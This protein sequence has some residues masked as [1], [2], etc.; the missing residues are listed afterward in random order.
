MQ[1]GVLLCVQG[2][3]VGKAPTITAGSAAGNDSYTIS[4]DQAAAG[5]IKFNVLINDPGKTT[6]YSLDD[7]QSADLL[8]QDAVLAPQQSRLGATI[9]ITADGQLS[10]A[11]NS[12]TVQALAVGETLQDSFIYAVRQQNGNLIWQTVTVTITGTNDAPV[13]VADV[14]AVAEDALATGSVAANDRDVDHNA[15][16]T[17]STTDRTPA[18]FT[19]ASNG[20]WAFDGSNAAYQSLA[21]GQTQQF[22]IQY[23]A[24]DQY[25]A[26]S[27]STLTLTVTGRNDAPAAAT[28][29]AAAT[30]DQTVTGQLTAT[31]VD[32]GGSL[33]FELNETAPAG[34]ALNANGSWSFD[35]SSYDSLAAGQTQTIT[36]RYAAVDGAGARG[37]AMLFIALTGTNAAPI[38]SAATASVGESGQASGAVSVTDVDSTY[39]VEPFYGAPGG[40]SMGADGSWSF[41]ASQGDYQS[42][43]AGESQDVVIDYIVTDDAGATAV[44]TLTITVTGENDAPTAMPATAAVAEDGTVSGQVQVS[45]PDANDSLTVEPPM[46]ANIAGFEMYSDG[47][48]IFDANQAE[49]Q[50]LAQGETRDI[51]INYSVS[52]IAGAYDYST[53]T[54]TITGANDAPVTTSQWIEAVEGQQ[55]SGTLIAF[56]QDNGAQLSF[57]ITGDAP[58]GLVVNADG[59]WVF[60]GSNSAYDF[61]RAGETRLVRADFSVTDEFGASASSFVTIAVTGTNDGPVSNGSTAVLAGSAEDTPFTFN[62]DDLLAGWS[63]PEGDPLIVTNLAANHGALTVE[64]GIVTYLPEANYNGPVALSYQVADA[65]GASGGAGSAT[66]A[67]SPVNDAPALTGSQAAPSG[68][69]DVTLTVTQAQLLQGWTDVEGSPLSISNVTANSGARITAN[70]NGSYSITPAANWNGTLQLSYSVSDGAATTAATLPVSFAATNDLPRLTGAAYVIPGQVEDTAFT[71]TTAQLLQGWTDVDGDALSIWTISTPGGSVT[72]N[73]D[74]TY[75]V[76]PA[77]NA[78]GAT[79][80]D[81]SIKD[82]AFPTVQTS[83]SYTLQA[84]NDPAVISGATT[85]STSEDAFNSSI[86]GVL[87]ATDVDNPANSFQS[88]SS[89][90]ALYGSFSMTAQGRWSYT[91]NNANPTVNALNDGETLTDSFVFRSIDG[92]AQTVTVTINGL[93]DNAYVSPAISTAPDANDFDTL[94]AT[95]TQTSTLFNFYGTAAS[96]SV[97]GSNGNDNISGQGGADVIYG[98]GGSDSLYGEVPPSNAPPLLGAAG[99]DTLYGQAGN[100]SLNGTLGNDRLYGGS[101]ADTLYGNHSQDTG[102]DTGSDWLYGGSGDDRLY[103]Q[104]GDDILVGGTGLDWLTGGSGADRFVYLSAQD[105]GDWLFDFQHGTDLIDISAFGLDPANFIGA[106]APGAVGPGEVGYRTYMGATQVE[107][108][109]YIDVDGIAG[110]DLEIRLI[111]VNGVDSSDFFWG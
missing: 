15:V 79:R 73:G 62:I 57:A 23:W 39:V 47:S 98:H 7:G 40:F 37:N 108:Y 101:G 102:T 110:A 24:T 38:A 66:F 35:A 3:K 31:D 13:A 41:D 60:D 74:G 80:I 33:T 49:Y 18:G 16:L 51:L 34:F 64:N 6:L 5:T 58:A 30:E 107:T 17:F 71:I 91:L 100:D 76:R 61:L 26:S 99:D 52:D 95:G 32:Q 63:D 20:S 9:A 68:S 82:A 4:E 96:E 77:A 45:D 54:V 69:E 10:Y 78:T 12:P 2:A 44:S 50:S 85:G 19:M 84:V 46:T 65:S 109:V 111:S 25:G 92:T 48:W 29:Y 75:T 105:T 59:S 43:G 106:I 27:S 89:T 104:S 70:A 83:L 28:G 97:D 14:A 8:T 22:V 90:A 94:N 55:A 56:D 11:F 103:G 87:T 72:N 93:S 86:S 81:Y 21:A 53:L 67:I 42:L 36:V 1:Q 88:V